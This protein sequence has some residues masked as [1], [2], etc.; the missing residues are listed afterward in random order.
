MQLPW[1]TSPGGNRILY[2]RMMYVGH[3]SWVEP[4]CA[5]PGRSD[6]SSTRYDYGWVGTFNSGKISGGLTPST[7]SRWS[8]ISVDGD[9]S[10]Y[11]ISDELGE[12]AVLVEERVEDQFECKEERKRPAFARQRS[13]KY[14]IARTRV[15]YMCYT[16]R[17][18]VARQGAQDGRLIAA[19][20]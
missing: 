4:T 8:I 5:V 10:V 18:W 20:Y 6:R 16:M 14:L 2:L 3:G 13:A 7:N 12:Y 1:L 15:R 11:W 19:I 17:T 9:L